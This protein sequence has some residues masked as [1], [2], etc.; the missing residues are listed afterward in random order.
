[1][2][3]NFDM[4]HINVLCHIQFTK[5]FFDTSNGKHGYTCMADLKVYIKRTRVTP[6]G[7]VGFLE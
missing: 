4:Q 6:N 1:M 7:I 5:N 3:F 2:N